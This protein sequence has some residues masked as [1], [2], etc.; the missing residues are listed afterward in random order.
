MKR[1]R[2]MDVPR[3]RL[4]PDAWR[5]RREGDESIVDIV[6]VS[7]THPLFKDRLYHYS[8]FD[9]EMGDLGPI[10]IRLVELNTRSG[11][12]TEHSLPGM[13]VDACLHAAENG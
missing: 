13:L 6:E 9:D 11:A 1:Y 2:L 5:V 8:R 3:L 4:V 12:E 10:S 7:D